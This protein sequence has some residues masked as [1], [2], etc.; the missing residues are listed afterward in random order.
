MRT[1][2]ELLH[3]AKSGKITD[4]E[5]EFILQKI[6]QSSPQD[7]YDLSLCYYLD[8]L[9]WIVSAEYEPLVQK[10][11][12]WPQDSMLSGLA[13]EI[14]C[15]RWG[16]T[17]KYLDQIKTFIQGVE[18]D[19]DGDARF[20]ALRCSG[21]YL[22][23]FEDKDLL[24]AVYEVFC[25]QSANSLDRETA[26]IALARAIGKD[27]SDYQLDEKPNDPIIRKIEARL[28]LNKKYKLR[29]AEEMYQG[30]KSG[31]VT[32]DEFE[33]AVKEL[34][35]ASRDGFNRDTYWYLLVVGIMGSSEYAP[36]FERFL[37]CPEKPSLTAAA[38]DGLCYYWSL[39]PKYIDI[40]VT[41]IK[42]VSWDT[43]ADARISAMRC[44]GSYLRDNENK[45]LLWMLMY[46]FSNE[47]E[48]E[49]MQE[50]AYMAIARAVGQSWE[51]YQ[52]DEKPNPSILK[53]AQ[54][55]LRKSP[56]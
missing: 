21:Y 3:A 1:P 56:P 44:A 41:F 8:V 27:R 5:L 54:D 24:N 51:E 4:E 46:V 17:A 13:I 15:C 16:L 36:L 12:N 50:T 47:E 55:K 34:E 53:R 10:F 23:S 22:S 52:K 20:S 49:V 35:S 11:I 32:Q 9:G 45:K 18:W 38:L 33:Y 48:N 40:L 42:G 26:Y 25:D 19:E 7:G 14:L 6:D 39:T 43:H 29:T 37:K 30:A 31:R 2:K 28:G